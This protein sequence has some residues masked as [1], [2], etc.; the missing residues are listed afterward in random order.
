MVYFPLLSVTAKNG[1]FTTLTYIF[2]HVCWL[3][4]T[5]SMISSRAKLLSRGA[6]FGGCDSFHSRLSLG[7]GWMLCVVSSLFSILMGCPVITPRTWGWYWQPCWLMVTGS[8]GTSNVRSPRPSFTYTNTLATSPLSTT[9][10]SEVLL[11]LQAG[12]WLM[13]IFAGLG[14][15]PLNL[16]VPLTVATVLGS[17]GVAGAAL[18][19]AL[20][21][22]AELS[23][24]SSFLL[25][26]ANSSRARRANMPIRA[27][28][29]LVIW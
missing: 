12:S 27:N 14:A 24:D 26:A 3:H 28:A 29:F 16:T 7:V 5:G 2:I 4:F 9:R 6:D 11:P 25:Q 8:L 20:V 22:F 18:V 13:S 10:D 1:L 21:S 19:A 23:C 17:M 15:V